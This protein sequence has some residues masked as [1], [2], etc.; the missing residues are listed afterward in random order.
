MNP[1]I[2]RHRNE[3]RGVLS[4]FDRVVITGTLTDICH[5]R[6]MGGYLSYHR[7]RLFDFPRWAEPLR[8]ELRKNAERLA[9]EAGVQI[10]F[11]RKLKAFRKEDRIKAILAERGEHPGLVHI[12][13]AMESCSSFQPWHDKSTHH[14][15][16][17]PSSGKCL[18]YYFYFIDEQF[19]LCYVRVPTWAPFRLQVYFNGHSWLARQLLQAA[20]PFEM[21]DNAFVSIADPERAQ[22]LADTLDAQRLHAHLDQWARRFSPVLRHFRSGYHWSFMQIEYATDVVFRR[23]AVFQPL[24]EAVVRT[25]VHVIKAEHVAMFLGHKLHGRFQGELGNDFSTRIQGT[26][27]RHSMGSASIKLYDKFALIARVECTAND[28]SFFKHHRYVEQRNGER[29]FKLARLRKSIYSLKDLRQ[30][31]RAANNRYLAFMACLDNPDAGQKAIA[32]MAAPA[33]RK[34]HS[35]RGFNLFLNPDYRLFLTLG[36]GEWAISGFRAADLRAHIPGLSPAR[37]SYILKRLRTHGLIKKV[38]HSYKYYLTT[39]GRRILV[40]ALVIR[41]Y[42]V[43]PALV[44][45]AL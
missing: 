36:R 34:G 14:T 37:S 42:F 15:L 30:V 27:I 24:Y 2:E 11:I 45:K 22:Q 26:R 28:V 21:A 19:G 12:F 20:I 33:K 39:L 1:F 38:A 5:A 8:D 29:V 41:E 13:S 31:M 10:E 17:K 16:L 3:I 18:H 9:A 7:I 43:Q 32:K 23:Q 4:C 35:F 6:A 25:A 44:R 40:T